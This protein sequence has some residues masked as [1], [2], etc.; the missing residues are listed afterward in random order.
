MTEI[1]DAVP[2]LRP[3]PSCLQ[4]DQVANVS[5]VRNRAVETVEL[6]STTF[7]QT[8]DLAQ[9]PM[10]SRS[11]VTRPTLL[12]RRLAVAPTASPRGFAVFAVF[13]GLAAAGSYYLYGS[14][15]TDGSPSADGFPSTAGSP[16]TV[17]FSA[18]SPPFPFAVCVALTVLSAVLLLGAIGVAVR[19]RPV[20]RG[21]AAAEDASRRGWYCGRCGVVYFQPGSVPTGAE[22]AKPYSPDEFRGIVF[23]AGGYGHLA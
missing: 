18:A 1:N 21:R 8:G 13:F 6:T 4:L 19:M 15:D 3:C 9:A 5:V 2:G 12:G 14:A 7:N 11:S 17:E 10:S 22:P 20:R 23:A 16:S